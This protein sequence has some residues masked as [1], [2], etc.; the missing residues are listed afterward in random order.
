MQLTN[1]RI[2]KNIMSLQSLYTRL[3][4]HVIMFRIVNGF[5]SGSGDLLHVLNAT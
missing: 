1:T 5:I 2:L 3:M 4:F